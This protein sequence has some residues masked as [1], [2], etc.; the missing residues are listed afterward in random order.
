MKLGGGGRA[1]KIEAKV[2]KEGGSKYEAGAVAG[3]ISREKYGAKQTAK[4]SA[5]GRK[6]N[7][8]K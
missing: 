8:G 4:W 2:R 1:A 5:E 6:R 3:M 7:K